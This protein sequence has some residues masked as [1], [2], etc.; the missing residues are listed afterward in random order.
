MFISRR[1]IF[2]IDESSIAPPEAEKAAAGRQALSLY[3]ANDRAIVFHV[4]N[5]GKVG[6]MVD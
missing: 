3:H 4:Q 6:I 1:S 2:P 5:P